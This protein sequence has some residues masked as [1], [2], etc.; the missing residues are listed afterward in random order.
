MSKG[1]ASVSERMSIQL[2]KNVRNLGKAVGGHGSEP[3]RKVKMTQTSRLTKVLRLKL[4]PKREQSNTMFAVLRQFPLA[5]LASALL[6]N[7][8][9]PTPG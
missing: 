5:P 1:R 8:L 4:A 3:S 7:S 9:W 2:P 6:A